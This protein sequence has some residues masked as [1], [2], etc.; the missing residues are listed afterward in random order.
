MNTR[1]HDIIIL[2]FFPF[3]QRARQTVCAVSFDHYPQ[4]RNNKSVGLPAVLLLSV[5]GAFKRHNEREEGGATCQAGRGGGHRSG[6]SPGIVT[7]RRE[8]RVISA[9]NP[10][11]ITW[12]RHQLRT[13]GNLTT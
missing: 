10:L 11:T 9:D 6:G 5:G 1:T 12:I 4:K 8:R 13:P 2:T 3:A 7:G